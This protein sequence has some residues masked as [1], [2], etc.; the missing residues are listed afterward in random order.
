MRAR[1]PA[2][3][4]L[5]RR[6]QRLVTKPPTLGLKTTTVHFCIATLARVGI[7]WHPGLRVHIAARIHL[8]CDVRDRDYPPGLALDYRS[9]T[10]TEAVLVMRAFLSIGCQALFAP[11]MLPEELHPR[12]RLTVNKTWHAGACI[13][14]LH[15]LNLAVPVN[16][17]DSL[18]KAR[19]HAVTHGIV[20]RTFFQGIHR[21]YQENRQAGT[22]WT[23]NRRVDI[24]AVQPRRWV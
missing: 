4:M 12:A 2:A 17:H 3:S 13:C 7:V 5:H 14:P 18:Q 8:G 19:I 6:V 20:I 22:R 10:C 16:R 9:S 24:Q 21:R 11:R 1:V 23:A 15:C